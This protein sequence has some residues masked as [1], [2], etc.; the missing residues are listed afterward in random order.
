MDY[1]YLRFLTEADA[2]AGKPQP[3]PLRKKILTEKTLKFMQEH[4][5]ED[6]R[7]FAE[8]YNKFVARPKRLHY[9][10]L[11]LL[12]DIY[13]GALLL[14]TADDQQAF[15]HIVAQLPAYTNRITPEPMG[16]FPELS[17]T[18]EEVLAWIQNPKNREALLLYSPPTSMWTDLRHHHI[19]LLKD[20]HAVEGI[21]DSQPFYETEYLINTYPLSLN[22]AWAKILKAKFQMGLGDRRIKFG[23]CCAKDDDL[24][25]S[26]ITDRDFIF[27]YWFNHWV[28][29]EKLEIYKQITAG[30]IRNA[31]V[32][33]YPLIADEDVVKNYL[34]YTQAQLVEMEVASRLTLNLFANLEFYRPRITAFD[35]YFTVD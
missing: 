23:V 22:D 20:N 7:K 14:M 27:S 17:I 28:S 32:L 11:V 16:Y 18:N 35:S 13:L 24:P 12:Y 29:N 9:I 3:N 10:D 5:E 19:V 6:H 8:D 4:T 33:A 1:D 26:Y 34:N 2:S 15:S 31:N 21:F 25:V 30:K